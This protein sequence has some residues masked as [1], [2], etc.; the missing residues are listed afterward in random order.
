MLLGAHY[1]NY[2]VS[3]LMSESKDNIGRLNFMDFLANI[4]ERPRNVELTESVK[5]AYDEYARDVIL[6]STLSMR[7]RI[8]PLK[9]GKS[10]VIGT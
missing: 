5:N 1:A 4:C 9:E 7:T 2:L 3:K 10:P 6:E 8:Y